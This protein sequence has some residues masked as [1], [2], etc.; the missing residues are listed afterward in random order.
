MI[1]T[2]QKKFFCD[3]FDS[4]FRLE[5]FMNS[6]TEDIEIINITDDNGITSVY[7]LQEKK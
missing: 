1:K 7:Y 3:K 6:F 2:P 5:I 4:K